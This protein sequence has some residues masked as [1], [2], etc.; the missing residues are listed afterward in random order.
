MRYSTLVLGSLLFTTSLFAASSALEPTEDSSAITSSQETTTDHKYLKA[1]PEATDSTTRFVINLP[2]K[3]RGDDTNYKVELIAGKVIETDGANSV[4]MATSLNPMPLKGWG[5]TYYDM[6]GSD[7]VR[8][9]MMAPGPDT[10]RVTKFVGGTPLTIRYNSRIPL[11]VY[12]PRGF[13]VR[14]RIWQTTDS[15]STIEQ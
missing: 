10:P 13:D 12:A 15:Y 5:F 3:E 6:T 2:H 9:T 14:Y 7:M 4:S 8:S 11:V 1:F